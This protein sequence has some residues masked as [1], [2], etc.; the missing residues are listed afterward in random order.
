MSMGLTRKQDQAWRF[1]H[2]YVREHGIPP[3]AAEVATGIGLKSKSGVH[4]VT[5][6]LEQ[7]GFIRRNSPLP[8]AME[9]LKAPLDPAGDLV[10]LRPEIRAAAVEFARRTHTS[11]STVIKEAVE[12]YVGGGGA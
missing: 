11:L 8:R 10:E 5:L 9:L 2:G 3:S 12:A 7:R 1:I 6:A 4:R